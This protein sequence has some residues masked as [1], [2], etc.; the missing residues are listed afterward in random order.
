MHESK[1]A[2]KNVQSAANAA[3]V[4]LKAAILD[5]ELPGGT[6][7]SEGAIAEQLGLS[8]TPIREAFLRL[9]TE[10]W[11]RLYPKRGALVIEVH[12]H[13]LE[14]ILEARALIEATAVRRF[15]SNGALLANLR[16]EL[17]EQIELQRIAH[18]S[19]D[20]GAFTAADA[21]FHWLIVKAGGNALLTDFFA[22][23][24]DR[25]QR[26]TARSLWRR[27]DIAA[28]V[29]A[30]HERLTEL[31]TLGDPDEFAATLDAHVRGTHRQLLLLNPAGSASHGSDLS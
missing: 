22:T 23:L 17:L 6:M 26:M 4:H 24:R 27:D 19:G 3:Y 18:E 16:S 8:R 12:P 30:E 11:M 25:Q 5:G 14:D 10:G 7:V 20:L 2:A 21:A 28:T 29:I 15:E 9:Q 13:E 31:I 1:T